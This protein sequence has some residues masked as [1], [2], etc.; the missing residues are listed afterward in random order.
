[1]KP[2][3]LEKKLKEGI[4]HFAFKKLNG[5]LRP[6]KGTTKMDLIPSSDHPKSGG[7]SAP[8]VVVFYDLNKNAWRSVSR[9]TEFIK[10][11]HI[12]GK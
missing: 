7:R 3:E 9:R 6:S 5:E 12:K 4:V 1:M 2:E 10:I 11:L 8:S